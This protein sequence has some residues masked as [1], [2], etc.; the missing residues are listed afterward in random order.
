VSNLEKV[1]RALFP[2]VVMPPDVWTEDERRA[3][4]E[5]GRWSDGQEAA[6][7]VRADAAAAAVVA[8]MRDQS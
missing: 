3:Y 2:F 6:R 1:A 4:D 5:G 7:K 8:W